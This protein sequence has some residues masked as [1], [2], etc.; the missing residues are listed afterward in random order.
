MTSESFSLL[1]LSASL[2]VGGCGAVT[3]LMLTAKSTLAEQ[4]FRDY[5]AYLD[6]ELSFLVIPFPG[7]KV[8][9]AQ[10]LTCIASVGLLAATRSPVV[11]LL[12]VIS[13]SAPPLLLWKRHVARVAQLDRQLDTWLLML[14]NALKSTSSVGEAIASTIALVP[15]PFSEE[16]DLLVKEIRLGAPLDRAVNAM[17]RRI[18]SSLISGA[19]ATIVV[20]RQTGGDLPRTLERASA[21]LRETNRLAG[22]LRTKTAEG[23]GQVLVLASVPFVL[24]VIIA[25]LDR[26]W[27]DPM[28]SHQIGK[29]ILAG[30]ALVWVLA[31]VWAYQIVKA[32]L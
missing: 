11:G 18:N 8:A 17:A 7:A 14:A 29:A 12:A 21:A 28:L 4:L 31:S 9:K 3:Y 13:V 2:V 15:K 30:C 24:C 22:V 6:R 5:A 19:L 25:W 10:L 20:A 16:V 23:R 26:S 32:D 27:F 1:L